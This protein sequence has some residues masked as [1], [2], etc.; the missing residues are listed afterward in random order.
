MGANSYTEHL[1]EEAQY[2]SQETLRSI[3]TSIQS[4][5]REILW[6]DEEGWVQFIKDHR[7]QIMEKSTEVYIDPNDAR[8]YAYS[9]ESFLKSKDLPISMAWIVVWLNQLYSSLH[10]ESFRVSRQASLCQGDNRSPFLRDGLSIVSW[11]RADSCSAVGRRAYDRGSSRSRHCTTF[12]WLVPMV[13]ES[14]GRD[15]PGAYLYS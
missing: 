11:L 9:V 7:K 12:R 14:R 2:N 8:I 6:P 10:L 3:I 5:R 4:D 1:K 13:G 15:I